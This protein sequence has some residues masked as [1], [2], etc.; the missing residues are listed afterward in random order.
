[1]IEMHNIIP[2]YFGVQQSK[3]VHVYRYILSMQIKRKYDM[4]YFNH[5]LI[6]DDVIFYQSLLR[7]LKNSAIY[8]LV[9]KN[10]CLFLLIVEVYKVTDL[11]TGAVYADKIISTEIFKRRATAKE[12]VEREI[13]IHR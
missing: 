11:V 5:S 13:N 2:V 3:F 7:V 8:F 6:Y 12:K 10:P 9:K 1:M 4:K